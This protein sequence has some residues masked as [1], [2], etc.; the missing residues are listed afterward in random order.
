[1]GTPTLYAISFS[2]AF[3]GNEGD[4]S[5]LPCLP[6]CLVFSWCRTQPGRG[7][8]IS[9]VPKKSPVCA[10]SL[11]GSL[12]LP[13]QRLN[14]RSPWLFLAPHPHLCLEDNSCDLWCLTYVGVSVQSIT[15]SPPGRVLLEDKDIVS[16]PPPPPAAPVPPGSC[17][18]GEE[19]G[20]ADHGSEARPPVLKAPAQGRVG[21]GSKVA[22]GTVS[23]LQPPHL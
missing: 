17:Q 2:S 12:L 9:L 21:G 5:V 13:G 23:Q 4:S 22:L 7:D 6:L 18:S 20:A 15:V 3:Y 11:P 14:P 10:V 1:M 8:V 16:R 19:A